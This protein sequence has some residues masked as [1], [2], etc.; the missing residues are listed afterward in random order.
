MDNI[1]LKKAR[2]AYQEVEERYIKALE[3]KGLIFDEPHAHE[4]ERQALLASL[5]EK[6]VAFRNGGASLSSGHL[7]RACVECTGVDGSET[8]STTFACHRDCY[9]CFN[10]NQ[11]D[12]ERFF[13]EGCPWEEGLDRCASENET[14]AAVGLTGGEPLLNLDDSIRFLEEAH[15][16]FPDAHLRMYTSGDLLTEEGA[17]RLADAHLDEIRFSVKDDDPASM[18]EKVLA[19]IHLAKRYI[20]SVMVEMPVIPGAEDHMKGLLRAFDEAGVDGIN[21]LEFCFPFC[22]WDEFERRGFKLKCPPFEVM[23]DYGYSGGLAVSGS[24]VLILKLMDWALDEGLSLGLHYC[25]LENKHRSEIRQKNERARGLHPCLT[26]DE[27]TFFLQAGKAFGQ[28]VEPAK[29]E[30]ERAGCVDVMQDAEEESITFPLAYM[31]DVMRASH[32][33]GTPLEPQIAYFVYETDEESGYF[34]DVAIRDA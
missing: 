12:Y 6:G 31:D 2:I 3:D 32:E 10:R 17:A 29:R 7:S 20:P 23:Y 1:A 5:K 14:L 8:F 13:R 19:A 15:R 18:Q 27:D 30:L 24:E 22:N 9:F 16:R 33:D 34:I 21:L 11:P 28:D 26:V 4:G 25:S